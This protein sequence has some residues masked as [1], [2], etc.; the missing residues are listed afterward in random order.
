VVL[1]TKHESRAALEAYQVHP[2][3]AAVAEF[4]GKVRADRAVVDYD[5]G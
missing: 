3:H 1:V 4:I 2:E 5:A